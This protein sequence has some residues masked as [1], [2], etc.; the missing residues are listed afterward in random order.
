METAMGFMFQPQWRL[1]NFQHCRYPICGRCGK[2]HIT[3]QCIACNQKC[4]KCKR[5]G[6]FARVCYS[7]IPVSAIEP[8]KQKVKSKKQKNRDIQRITKY[9]TTRKLMEE[10]PFSKI[11]N[12]AFINSLD[13]SA[14]IKTELK[15]V[16][17]KLTSVQ[18]SKSQELCKL[19]EELESVTQKLKTTQNELEK[20]KK[21]DE[22]FHFLRNK[23]KEADRDL[24]QSRK[25]VSTLEVDSESKISDLRS[26]LDK[27]GDMLIKERHLTAKLQG[28]VMNLQ[29]DEWENKI[30]IE[31]LKK[32]L[33]ERETNF[34]VK[35]DGKIVY[36]VKHP[37]NP[38][39]QDSNCNR[40]VGSNRG[41][42]Y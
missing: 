18:K 20:V 1:M 15:S 32:Q 30:I 23:L 14:H 22:E 17:E 11:R 24:N 29:N 27:V 35:P 3:G 12:N 16:K 8:M 13:L 40:S 25:M 9:V 26:R 7:K 21:S 42:R 36:F 10:L 39:R 28:D 37:K 34:R 19:K 31:H 41:R 2:I 33:P 38:P 6:H 5:L 4:F